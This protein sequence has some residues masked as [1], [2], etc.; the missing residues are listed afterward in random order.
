[1][2]LAM[3]GQQAQMAPE[4][5]EQFEQGKQAGM[6]SAALTAA[7]GTLGGALGASSVGKAAGPLVPAG[8]DAAGRMLPWIASQIQTQGPSLA[9]QGITAG[10]SLAQAHPIA[11]WGASLVAARLAAKLGLPLRKVLDLVVGAA[12]GEP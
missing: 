10:V 4:D 7:T 3:S 9:K 2:T 1:M 5:Q 6:T 11:A 8:R 12:P